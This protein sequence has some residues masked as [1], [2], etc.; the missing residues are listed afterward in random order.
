MPDLRQ[1][2][3]LAIL[4]SSL[5]ACDPSAIKP[6]TDPFLGWTREDIRTLDAVDAENP[7]QDLIAIYTRKTD[8]TLDIRLDFLDQTDTLTNDIYVA[9]DTSPAGSSA[10]PFQGRSDLEWD[11][12]L[13]LTK[14]RAPYAVNSELQEVHTMRPRVFRDPF[15]DAAVI[16][17]NT[18]T[19]NIPN[20]SQIQVWITPTGVATTADASPVIS[21]EDQWTTTAPLILEFWNT[22]P[23]ATPAQ[24]LRRWD[25]AH[26]GPAGQRHGLR[27]LLIAV[28]KFDI[29][30]YLLDLASTTRISALELVGGLDLVRSLAN[31]SK[32]ILPQTAFSPITAQHEMVENAVSAQNSGI[33]LSEP[34]F[35]PIP[36]TSLAQGSTAF[37]D[38]PNRAH[39]YTL[40][41]FRLIPTASHVY[42]VDLNAAQSVTNEGLTLAARL[43]LIT[44]ALSEDPS[45]LVILGGSLPNSMWGDFSAAT[46]AF[47]FISSHP[48]IQ[49]I[50]P[51]EL[52]R[53]PAIA[54]N[55]DS[56]S[57]ADLLC[58]PP[59]EASIH[60]FTGQRVEIP[61]SL[62]KLRENALLAAQA[63]SS[64]V[65]SSTVWETLTTLTLPT[66]DNRAQG[67]QANLLGFIGV[68]A[69]FDT[70][71]VAPQP[72]SNCEQD[73]DWDGQGECVLAS[74]SIFTVIDLDGGRLILAGMSVNNTPEQWIGPDYQLVSG[75]GDPNKYD[76]KRGYY[77][78]LAQIPGALAS[79]SSSPAQDCQAEISPD[80]MV[81]SCSPGSAVKRVDL[82]DRGIELAVNNSAAFQ[83]DI[84]LLLSPEHRLAPGEMHLYFAHAADN[85]T[86]F[87]WAWGVS[88]RLH[89]TI[90]GGTAKLSSALDNTA[91][92]REPE[93]PDRGISPDFYLP[94]PLAVLKVSSPGNLTISIERE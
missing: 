29:P 16:R 78:D 87:T 28:E 73:L 56:L 82:T 69:A 23:S 10:L 37:A 55:S 62:P 91:W 17:L 77:T 38:L 4:F 64:D 6:E 88:T 46:S 19:N 20:N 92:L 36:I 75:L 63:V 11:F 47:R 52:S 61:I 72:M 79:P 14:T 3:A 45:D 93:N 21:F 66:S 80:R 26:T 31:Q 53:W 39:I 84:P 94:Y 18:A 7:A 70:W 89:I 49:T 32:I 68:L 22:L 50:S 25:G 58:S 30:V 33:P 48:W 35:A 34:V 42:T 71:S 8:Q 44:A 85:G 15:L 5:G 41:G 24:T 74:S 2:I 40:D 59:I 57:C 13:C 1:L 90:T 65:I 76:P 27:Q 83:T 51:L 54:I 9:F 86:S 67:L 81:L 12:L 43:D 60:P